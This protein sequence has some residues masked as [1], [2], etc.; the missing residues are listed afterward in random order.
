VRC[1]SE[2]LFQKRGINEFDVNLY[3]D[4]P[5]KLALFVKKVKLKILV[6][7][8]LKGKSL[9]SFFKIKKSEGE[10]ESLKKYTNEDL[11]YIYWKSLAKG[12]LQVKKFLSL[13]ENRHKFYY[14]LIEGD[15][16][17]KIS[18]LALWAYEAF[19][20]GLEFEII[21]PEFKVNSKEGFDEVFKKLALY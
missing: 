7:P 4:Y 12:D 17:E 2:F 5:L 6:Y 16:E 15:K 13:N 20:N 1:E 21:F 10:F 18:Q 8:E 11:K 14:L 9:D 19:K 3:C